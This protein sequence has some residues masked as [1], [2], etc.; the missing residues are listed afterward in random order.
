MKPGT[1]VKVYG[2]ILTSSVWVESPAT[3][4]VWIAMLVLADAEGCVP[5]TVPGLANIAAVSRA[6]CE[7]ALAVLESPDFDSRTPTEEGR[8]VIRVEG[9]WQIVN[10]RRYRDLRT[11]KQIADADRQRRHREGV[12]ER[13]SHDVSRLSHT[14]AEVEVEELQVPTPTTTAHARNESLQGTPLPGG[15]PSEVEGFLRTLRN[16]T[17]WQAEMRMW[18]DGGREFPVT[19]DDIV[20]AVTDYLANAEGQVNITRFR[21]YIRRAFKTRKLAEMEATA[22]AGGQATRA[23]GSG[24][25]EAWSKLMDAGENTPQGRLWRKDAVLTAVDERGY[26]AF[27]AIG[28]NERLRSLTTKDQVWARKEF[29]EA[30]NAGGGA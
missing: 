19:M 1:F 25:V 16:P 21:G 18:L 27:R 8:R 10:H 5:G 20:A 23:R 15:W 2:S 9:G 22:E 6:D 4:K 26:A 29:I 24:A 28:G 11:D 12:T 3:V 13:D 7:E 17:H 14:E 30:Y